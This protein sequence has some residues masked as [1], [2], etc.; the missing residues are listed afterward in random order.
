[1]YKQRGL[2]LKSIA[3][4]TCL[5]AG[6]IAHAQSSVTLYGLVDGG[7]LY[8]NKT[9]NTT[10]GQNA[11]AQ[12]SMID[13]GNSPSQFGL[14]GTEDLGGGMKAKF[15]L[16]SGI[17]LANGAFNDSNGNLFG[18]QAYVGLDSNYGDT[19]LGL[20]FSPFFLSMCDLDPRDCSQFAS[21]LITYVDNPIATGILNANAISYTSPK[22]AGFQASAMLGLGG[23][24]GDF[25]AG[26]NYSVDLKYDTGT[27]LVEAGFYDG[28][29]GGA[30]TPIPTTLAF[31]GRIIGASYKFGKLTAK[32][33]FVN[34]KVTGSFNNNVY[35]GGLDWLAMPTLDLNGGVWYT[36]DRNNTTNH[37]IM[38]GIGSDYYLS[39]ATT[40]YAQ[41]GVVNNHG[42]MDTGLSIDG[43]L[44][45]VTGT[46][47]GVD[48]GIRHFF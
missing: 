6:G 31:E 42:S 48:I 34:Y 1:M 33:S 38:G 35:G 30:A 29:A 27:L 24:A 5:L 28:N 8:T 39:R 3:A 47:V 22:I 41:F 37:S 23:V 46:T 20:Q 43:A 15:K 19:K 45:G 7:L 10:T 11:G 25:Q 9:L 44:N 12:F 32:F 18:R 26:R 2:R 17:S 36:S 13:S 4:T 21:G 14:M 16:E 40:L